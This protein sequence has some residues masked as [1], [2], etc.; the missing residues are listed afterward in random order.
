[1]LFFIHAHNCNV[2]KNDRLVET[3]VTEVVSNFHRMHVL[4]IG[5]GLGRCPLVLKATARIIQAARK[6]NLPLVIDADGLF[7]LTQKE[8]QNILLGYERAV[9]TPNVVE[10]K[11]LVE[12]VNDQVGEDQVSNADV[13]R[14]INKFSIMGNVLVQKG[15]HDIITSYFTDEQQQTIE[16]NKNQLKEIQMICK[17]E[18]GLKRSGG[19]GD[20]LS[21]CMGAFLAWN[22]ILKS[23]NDDSL[24]KKEDMVLSCWSACCVTKRATKV[25][26]EKKRR[27]M[28]APDILEELGIVFDEM[29]KDS[30][31][32]T[33]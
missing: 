12:S 22:N 7:L 11:R 4:I 27:S 5:P 31:M 21:G 23:D 32:I 33:I 9:L 14:A 24:Q 28:T 26:F 17:E 30:Y 19:I 10:M 25:A 6:Q 13:I 16:K 3:M 29:T 8:Y 20:I 18:G 2:K 15:K 1:V